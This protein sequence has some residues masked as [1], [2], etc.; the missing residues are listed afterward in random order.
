MGAGE[1]SCECL[2]CGYR[3]EDLGL[4]A[5]HQRMEHGLVDVVF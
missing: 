4:L 5:E 3:Y 1:G 2:A